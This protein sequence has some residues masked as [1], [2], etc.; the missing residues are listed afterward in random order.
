MW[1]SASFEHYQTEAGE[2]SGV[3]VTH[4]HAIIPVLKVTDL[5]RS[6]DW[7][8]TVL[9]FQSQAVSPGD[10]GGENCFVR[11]GDLEL[12]LSTGPHLGGPPAFTGTLYFRVTGVAELYASV[13]GRA[14]IVWPLEDQEYGTREFGVRDPDGYVLAFAEPSKTQE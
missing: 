13:N 2:R 1:T 5:R 10:G 4:F 6:I 9:G 12:L 14:E 3:P 7:Y 11:A 8:F